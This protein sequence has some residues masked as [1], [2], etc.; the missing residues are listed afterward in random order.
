MRTMG[1]IGP[2]IVGKIIARGEGYV[3]PTCLEPAGLG[4]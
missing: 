4:P 2:A 3:D 1:E